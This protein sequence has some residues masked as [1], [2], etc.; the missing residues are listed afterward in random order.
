MATTRLSI[1]AFGALV[2]ASIAAFFVTQHLKVSTPLVQGNPY[3]VPGVINPLH[4]V[5]CGNF[6]NGSTKISFYLQN[7]SDDVNVYVVG[8]GGRVVRTVAT[9]RHMRKNVRNPDGVFHWDG[10]LSDGRIAPDGTYYFRVRLI[11]SNRTIDLKDVPVKVKTVAPHPVITNVQP[12]TAGPGTHVTISYAGNENR[13]GT[14]LIYQLGQRGG[15]RLIKTFPTP[16][17]G[18]SAVWDGTVRDQQPAP[19]GTYLI[20][21][22]VTDAACITGQYPARITPSAGSTATDEVTVR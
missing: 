8:P 15:P 22:Q 20:A 10:R 16:W 18:R 2:V 6:D 12:T 1:A 13:G 4:P 19:A 9:G 17:K 5:Q 21:L 7:H 14:I 11:N 3:P